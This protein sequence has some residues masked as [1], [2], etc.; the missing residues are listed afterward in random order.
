MSPPGRRCGNRTPECALRQFGIV[1]SM[2]SD[3]VEQALSIENLRR[4]G[5]IEE[6]SRDHQKRMQQIVADHARRGLT[7][8]GPFG[9]AIAQALVARARVILAK[10]IELRRATLTAVPDVHNPHSYGALLADL[11]RMIETTI[12]AIP[13]EIQRRTGITMPPLA[14]PEAG[15]FEPE[16]GELKAFARREVEIMRREFD[17]NLP[18]SKQKE[19]A[20][21]SARDPRKVWVVYG[22]NDAARI[23]MFQFLRSINLDPMEWNE[24]T[25]LAEEGAPYIGQVLDNAFGAVQAVI[26]L[27]SGDEFAYLRPEFVTAHDPIYEGKPTPQARPN[28]LFE[29]G[30]AF[31]RHPES[32]VLVTLGY[33]RPFSDVAGRHAIKISNSVADRQAL[34]ARLKS[35]GCAAVTET[36]TDW[37]HSGDFDG[38]IPNQQ[39][40]SDR[41]EDEDWVF[42]RYS[43]SP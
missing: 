29:A 36:R 41:E 25:A 10:Y 33:S 38:A 40:D 13:E 43:C 2:K 19:N 31:G 1:F 32:T 5:V 27:L 24:A 11:E 8:S 37:H 22:R 39:P 16:L 3:R 35:I 4:T 23:A 28:V 17:M 12:K 9:N 30:M 6:I 14:R 26:V 21:E 7:S 18:Q 15:Q 34:A 20:P 42:L